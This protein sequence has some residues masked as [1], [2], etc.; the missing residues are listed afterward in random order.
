M[1]S[2]GQTESKKDPILDV[3]CEDPETFF[4]DSYIDNKYTYD[5]YNTSPIELDLRKFKEAYLAMD[6]DCMWTLKTGCKV[7]TVIY[8]FAKK[9]HKESYLHSFII[10]DADVET[11]SLFSPDEWKEIKTFEVT[12]G[13]KLDP[14]QKELLKKYTTNDIKKLRSLFFESFV[15]DNKEYNR[16][17]H[18]CLEYINTAY[19]GILCLWEMNENPFDSLKLEG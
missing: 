14:C 5:E 13:P 12:N 7:E 9:L 2:N 1:K 4:N 18:F 17:I 3:A 19:H 10:N 6:P 11:I 15:P 16:D 8:E